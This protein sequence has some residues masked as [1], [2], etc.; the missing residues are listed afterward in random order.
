MT[1]FRNVA[2]GIRTSAVR[3]PQAP[4]RT[5]LYASGDSLTF[6]VRRRSPFQ[7]M[8]QSP[9]TSGNRLPSRVEGA[10]VSFYPESDLVA[11]GCRQKSL[12]QIMAARSSQA[13]KYDA[14]RL[15]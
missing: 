15:A 6:R 11:R 12:V 13:A 8:P 14:A 2:V 5:L 4:I 1:G 9:S 10:V 3:F 7:H